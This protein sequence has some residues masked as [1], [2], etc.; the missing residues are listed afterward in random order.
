MTD[1]KPH[2][3]LGKK[4]GNYGQQYPPTVLDPDEVA[5]LVDACT[6]EH[7]GARYRALIAVLYRTG[8]KIGEALDLRLD[9]ID[10]EGR[11]VLVRGDD[12]SDLR[13]RTLGID[14]PLHLALAEWLHQRSVLDI[15]GDFVFCNPP[16]RRVQ[17]DRIG[18]P[19][20]DSSVRRVLSELAVAAKLQQGRVHPDGLRYS[21]VAQLIVE[22]WPMAYIQAQ[23]GMAT[24]QAMQTVFK[25]LDLPLP[26]DED[27]MLVSRVRRWD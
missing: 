7:T 1:K 21:F 4:P 22:G 10:L 13:R 27:V 16:Q 18:K 3:R 24:F 15:P 12:E 2:H 23:L 26:P 9:D 20:A 8:M 19:M 25:H 17:K 11:T 6:E 5:A 14:R